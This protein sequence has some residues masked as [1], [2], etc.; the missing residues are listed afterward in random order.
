MPANDRIISV[1]MVSETE[2]FVGV[3]P[4]EMSPLFPLEMS[5]DLPHEMSPHP[6]EMS[7]VRPL[8]MSPPIAPTESIM[9]ITKE[10]NNLV[11][12]FFMGPLM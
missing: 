2:S 8:E 11:K 10:A 12:V 9:Q 3:F 4:L 1:K 7:P 6:L 5:P